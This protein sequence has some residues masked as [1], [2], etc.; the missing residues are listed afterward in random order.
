MRVESP[1]WHKTLSPAL[2]VSTCANAEKVTLSMII[3]VATDKPG[4][5]TTGCRASLSGSATRSQPPRS[6]TSCTTPGSIPRPAA[7][8]Y[9]GR[10]GVG[11]GRAG[12]KPTG[13][14]RSGPTSGW[15]AFYCIP[16]IEGAQRKVAR[17]AT[18]AGSA[19][20]AWSRSLL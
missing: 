20:T 4:R 9:L 1:R 18:S 5:G 6:G 3:R 14:R 12:W 13:G 8:A 15:D 17:K 11:F 16:G 2:E 19:A 10:A 7:A